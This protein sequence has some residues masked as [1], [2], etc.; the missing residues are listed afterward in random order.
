VLSHS[1]TGWRQFVV[2]A[3]PT[4]CYWKIEYIGNCLLQRRRQRAPTQPVSGV[5]RKVVIDAK[6]FLTVEMTLNMLDAVK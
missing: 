3:P 4:V 6:S 1:Q 5:N 2:V